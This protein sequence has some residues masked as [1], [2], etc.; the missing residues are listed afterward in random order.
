M[1][2]EKLFEFIAKQKTTEKVAKSK[3]WKSKLT[4]EKIKN[5]QNKSKIIKKSKFQAK[6]DAEFKELWYNDCRRS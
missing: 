1:T 5:F 4:T 3:V 2:K 6:I